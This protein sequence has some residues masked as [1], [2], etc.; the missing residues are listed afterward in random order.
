MDNELIAQTIADTE[1]EKKFMQ[2]VKKTLYPDASDEGIVLAVE[3][4]RA[5][6][7]D[8]MLKPIYL[9]SYGGKEQI[10]PSITL[11][12]IRAHRSGEYLGMSEP[13]FG[14][15]ITGMVGKTKMTYPEYCTITIKR[16][17]KGNIAEFSAKEYFLENVGT[18]ADKLSPTLF[19]YKRPFG[20]L[21]KVAE[22]QVLKKAFP[23][24]I[25]NVPSIEELHSD[26][27]VDVIEKEL[28]PQ[29]A[30]TN[31]TAAIKDKFK[32]LPER[33]ILDK[34]TG[35]S[36][37][38]NEKSKEELLD[39][40]RELVISADITK[41]ALDHFK[42]QANVKSFSEMTLVQ[43]TGLIILFN[44]EKEGANG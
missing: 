38:L 25:P 18:L 17:V 22:N 43:L 12:R 5:M 19:W 4:C 15:S 29:L 40:L 26:I 31:A 20:Q 2:L 30:V 1:K 16:L 24:I 34:E 13:I 33:S 41:E 28:N 23:E 3:Y 27:K 10:V 14:P 42:A 44:E 7:L 32:D 35:E 36:I 37:N 39:I 9:V 8:I 11:A 6:N 21:A